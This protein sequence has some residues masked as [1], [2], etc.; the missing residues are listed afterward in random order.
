VTIVH[1]VLP[2]DPVV[3]LAAYVEH[4][5][6]GLGLDR[7]RQLSPDDVIAEITASGLRGRGGAG[8]PTG[9]KWRTV[10]DNRS[11]DVAATVVVNAAEGEPGT[12]KDRAILLTNP[13]AVLEG[14]L[15]AAHAVDAARVVVGSKAEFADVNRRLRAAIDEIAAAGWLGSLTVD[16]VEGPPEYLYGEETALLEVADGRLPFPRVNPPYRRGYTEVVATDDD[17]DSGSGLSATVEMAGPTSATVAPPALVN[18]VETLANVAKIIDRG[19]EWFRTEGTKR[20]PGTVVV[21]ISG[22]TK[23]AGVGEVLLGSRLSDA[24]ADIGGGLA[25]GARVKAVLSGVSNPV[26][27]GDRLGTF[28]THDDLA[29]AGSGLGS[30]GFIVVDEE[31]SMVAVAAGV[32]RFLAVESCGQCA[33]CKDDGLALAD[34]L[35]RLRGTAAAPDDLA[36]VNDRLSTIAEGARCSL[37]GQ[38]QAVVGSI[39]E[40]FADEFDRRV[41]ESGPEIDAYPIAELTSVEGGLA[42]IDEHQARKQPDWSYDEIGSSQWP[43]DRFADHRALM[44]RDHQRLK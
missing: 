11:R 29:T 17:V 5:R 3:D 10:R 8:F 25:A 35:D 30:A 33:R 23:R 13:F 20:S 27:P 6:G 36:T 40:L 19:A 7:A 43:A 4:Q 15:I 39:V 34:A 14:A 21:T 44:G 22:A 38:Q 32:A 26:L 42:Q 9:T 41:K 28:V 2:P 37:A 24:I 1:R 16:V 12:F 31:T 18:N